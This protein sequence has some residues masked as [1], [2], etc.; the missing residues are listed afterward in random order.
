MLTLLKRMNRGEKPRWTDAATGKP[1]TGHGFR[2]SFKTWADEIAT[3]PNA[4]VEQAMGHQVGTQ[5]ERVYS[6]TDLL[7]LRRKLMEAWSNFCNAEKLKGVIDLKQ[8][9]SGRGR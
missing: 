8:A 6:R 9:V 2:A 3:F 5:S 7:D 1:I 4:V